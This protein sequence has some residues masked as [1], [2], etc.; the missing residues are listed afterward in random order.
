MMLL[1]TMVVAH[2]MDDFLVGKCYL[3]QVKES[4]MAFTAIITVF[5]S[6]N[7]KLQFSRP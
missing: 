6:V 7:H 4:F 1:P 5:W 2:H 3:V